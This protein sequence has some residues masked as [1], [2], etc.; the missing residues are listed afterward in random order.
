MGCTAVGWETKG[1][2]SAEAADGRVRQPRVPET[3]KGHVVVVHVIVMAKI[4]VHTRIPSSSRKSH[5]PI[6]AF[7]T[8]KD[9]LTNTW[10]QVGRK[11]VRRRSD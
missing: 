1:A 3:V 4:H 10:I 7:V 5:V 11:N 2:A 9:V 8:P 6:D